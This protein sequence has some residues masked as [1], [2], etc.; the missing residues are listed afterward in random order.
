MATIRLRRDV[1]IGPL[2]P[3]YADAMLRWMNDPVI[4]DNLGLRHSPSIERTITWIEHAQA[5]ADIRCFAILLDGR[6]VGNVVI[7][8]LDDYLAT[9]RLSVYVGEAKA[10]STGVGLSG[11][12]LAIQQSFVD[13]DLHKIWLTVHI[14]NHPAI[15]TYT[16]LNF[17]LEGILRD[18]FWLHG[19]RLSVLYMGLL[20][21]DFE[22]LTVDWA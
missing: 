4:S 20:R 11:M 16:K 17:M 5:A 7:D 18:E 12:Y 19:A 22:S 1:T 3:E 9:G 2:L 21:S 8:R 10:R 13:L 14:H 6:H 15:H